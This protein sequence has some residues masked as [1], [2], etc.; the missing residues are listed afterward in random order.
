MKFALTDTG[1]AN[2]ITA[3]SSGEFR[4][5]QQDFQGSLLVSTHAVSDGWPVNS[6]AEIDAQVI[7]ALLERK[8]QT[9]IIGTGKTLQF[10]EYELLENLAGKHVGV[11]VMDTPAA[12]RTYNILVA[13]G[14]NVLAALIPV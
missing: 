7:E 11:E 10:P 1:E 8:P 3:Y 9:I 2:T 4:V 5:G 6:V 13:E 14:R 12:C